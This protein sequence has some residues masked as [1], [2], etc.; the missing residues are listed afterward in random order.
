MLQKVLQLLQAGNNPAVVEEA[1]ELPADIHLP[2]MPKEEVL[3][4]DEKLQDS[5]TLK[6]LVGDFG[7]NKTIVTVQT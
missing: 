4:L 6:Q 2:L 1:S 7:N 5:T 3:A